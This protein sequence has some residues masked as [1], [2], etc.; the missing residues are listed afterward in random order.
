MYHNYNLPLPVSLVM[1]IIII[2]IIITVIV[3][4]TSRVLKI[5]ELQKI[6]LLGTSHILRKSLFIK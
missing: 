3:I 2:I 6:T 4:I 5:H 1:I